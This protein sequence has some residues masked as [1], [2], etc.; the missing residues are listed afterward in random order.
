[1]NCWRC[2][3]ELSDEMLTCPECGST[4]RAK[5]RRVRCRHCGRR[6]PIQLRVC[7]FCGRDLAKAWPHRLVWPLVSAAVILSVAL[8]AAKYVHL[9]IGGWRG[10]TA[11]RLQGAANWLAQAP[12]VVLPTVILPPSPTQTATPTASS[13]PT[14]TASATSTPSNT[15]TPTPLP[16][17]SPTTV[18]GSYRVRSGDTPASIALQFNVSVEKLMQVNDIT[19]PGSLQVDQELT[20]P[21]P[22]PTLAPPTPAPTEAAGEGTPEALQTPEA[23]A[24]S[25]TTV[26]TGVLASAPVAT[27][28]P[29]AVAAAAAGERL[30][31]VV[32]GD[33][34]S[35]IAQEFGVSVDAIMSAN[36]ITDPLQLQV[37]QEL[38]IPA[39]TR[40]SASVPLST[41]AAPTPTSEPTQTPAVATPRAAPLP[42]NPEDGTPYS[43]D[44]AIIELKWSGADGLGPDEEFVVHVGYL[45]ADGSVVWV[46]DQ[47]QEQPLRD[48]SWYVPGW[49]FGLAPQESGRTYVWYIQVER[50]VRDETGAFTGER[51]PVSAPSEQYRFSWQ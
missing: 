15:H 45:E 20:I 28:T 27:P 51:E 24:P 10:T 35:R 46:V 19:D 32:P 17:A 3:A 39:P 2:N 40:D 1:M 11:A 16:S 36:G 49:V 7:P 48:L 38:A 5:S 47:P 42:V 8:L 25:P 6:S 18:Y 9:D 37:S 29:E 33:T 44:T 12:A 31:K 43:G 4:R 23:T 14:A 21:L 22:E 26:A 50:V 41:V 34:L 13:T 30:Y